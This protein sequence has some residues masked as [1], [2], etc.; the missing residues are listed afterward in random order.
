MSRPRENETLVLSSGNTIGLA[1][2][3]D[4]DGPVVFY[5]H[6]QGSSRLEGVWWAKPAEAVG[7]HIIAL[8]R[9][10][11]G[12]SSVQ[13]NRKMLDWPLVVSEVAQRINIDQFYVLGG[14]LGGAYALACAKE[15]S[16]D[17][18]KGVGVVSCDPP[19]P[20]GRIGKMAGSLQSWVNRK[21]YEKF[22]VPAA[23]DPDPAVF[24]KLSV[25]GAR[26][27]SKR[28]NALF[29]NAEFRD[30]LVDSERECYRQGGQGVTDD[31][32]T[33]VKDWGFDIW[34][35]SVKVDMWC[36]DDGRYCPI[37]VNRSMEDQIDHA[38]L[39]EFEGETH[40]SILATKGEQILRGLLFDDE[41][42]YDH[43]AQK[44]AYN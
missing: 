11:V 29:E 20:R 15:L 36:G 35:I 19:M 21:A 6:G 10:G 23:K 4:L 24:R 41:K 27:S 42:S 14:E 8:D 28:D 3:G 44:D 33:Y 13:P 32:R 22:F 17:A 37:K 30:F 5:F 1:H 16:P 18:L 26:T 39:V 7:A 38:R 25:D 2:Y 34:N 31:V 40:F 43:P 12:L 9:P